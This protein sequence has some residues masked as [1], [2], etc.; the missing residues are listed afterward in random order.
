MAGA[1]PGK[2]DAATARFGISSAEAQRR[3]GQFGPNVVAEERPPRWRTFLVKFWAPV[4]W[5][6]EATI[7]LQLALGETVEAAV[8][9]FLLAFNGKPGERGL[10]G[11]QTAA[12]PDCVGMPRRRLDPAARGHNRAG[13]CGAAVAGSGFTLSAALAAQTLARRGVLLTRLSAAHEAAM[14]DVLCS[15]KTGTLTQNALGVV[16]GRA[17][18][19]EASNAVRASRISSAGANALRTA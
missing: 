19:T 8:V 7:V 9:G 17:T 14:M 6:L 4:P 11:A 10:G 13:R 12:R 2:P 18:G 16:A 1:L 5:M 3:L 15:D